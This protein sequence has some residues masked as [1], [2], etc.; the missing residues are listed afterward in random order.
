MLKLLLRKWAERKMASRAPDFVIGPDR[1]PPYIRRW[2]VIPRNKIFN[3]YLHEV[4]QDDDDRAMHDHPWWNVSYVIEGG[5]NEITPQ[6]P[7]GK[8]L[9]AGQIR[10]RWASQLHRLQLLTHPGRTVTLFITGPRIREWGFMC[11][12]GIG[13]RHWK[14]FTGENKGVVG[15]GC[16][17]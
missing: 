2:W 3:I 5:Y 17:D 14:I 12:E 15:R 7:T 10:F 11:P 8:K 16:G 4:Q 13:W 1:T 6:W 9:F